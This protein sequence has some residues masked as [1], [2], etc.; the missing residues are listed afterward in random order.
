MLSRTLEA[1]WALPEPMRSA[2]LADLTD[3]E[4]AELE[5]DWSFWARPEQRW[6]PGPERYTLFLAGRFFGKTA[7]GANAIRFLNSHP[8]LCEGMT[9]LA[10]RTANETNQDL[11]REGILKW[12][13]EDE[14]PRWFRSD[15]LLEWPNRAPW[16]GS[17][18][19]LFSGDVPEGFRGPN[20]G[21]FWC[22]ELP[23]W[24]KPKESFD[25][26]DMMVRVGPHPVIIVTT[27]P[28]GVPAIVELAFE[29]D[30]AGVPIGK[31]GAWQVRD[32]VRLVTGSTYDNVAN[33]PASYMNV[34]RRMEGTRLGLQ[35]IHGQILLGV[36]GALWEQAWVGRVEDAPELWRVV[37]AVDPAVSKGDGSAETGIVVAGA[38]GNGRFYVL[39]DASGHYSPEGWGQRVLDLWEKWNAWA[40]VEEDN[41]GGNLVEQPLRNLINRHTANARR[42]SPLR[43]ERVRATKSKAKRAS[44]VCGLWELGR[45][46]HVGSPRR[47]VALE[48]QLTHFDPSKPDK[49]QACDRMDALVWAMLYLSGDGTDRAPVA[50][51]A[52]GWG[53]VVRSMKRR[54]R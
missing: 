47:F 34:V 8:D 1:I 14:K 15:K 45:V 4:A 25:T 6:E 42:Y 26:L 23:H 30:E 31:E 3:E 37:V 11:V 20:M 2:A 5:H 16:H 32:D 46:F 19:R 12:C 39:E 9:G 41:Q 7:T 27:T 53:D 51:Q 29:T 17:V 44:L 28:L 54:R 48:H 33:A 24:A 36:P 43:I 22:D 18:T 40:V 21:A 35:E 13:R 10:G 49:G 38:D 50:S 52:R